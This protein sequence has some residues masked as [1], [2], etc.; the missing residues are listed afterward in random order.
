MRRPQPLL[1][2]ANVAATSAGMS[3]MGIPQLIASDLHWKTAQA[4]HL[5]TL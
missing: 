2:T 4:G 5:I 3:I 1:V